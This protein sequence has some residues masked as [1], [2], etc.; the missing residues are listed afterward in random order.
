MPIQS[1]GRK[2]WEGNAPQA[3]LGST[4]QTGHY[5]PLVVIRSRTGLNHHNLMTANS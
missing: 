2:P 4:E 5:C 3:V 1:S